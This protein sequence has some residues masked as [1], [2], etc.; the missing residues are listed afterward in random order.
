MEWRS[1]KDSTNNA[2]I[3]FEPAAATSQNTIHYTI[4]AGKHICAATQKYVIIYR[5]LDT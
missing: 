4:T 5:K 1:E 2:V 3:G